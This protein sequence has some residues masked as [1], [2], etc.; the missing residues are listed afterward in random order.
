[1]EKI[2]SK[3]NRILSG[4]TGWLMV[5]MMLLL[6]ADVA[7]RT[8]GKPLQGVAEIS[9]FVMMIVIYLGF[10]RC[11]EHSE[12]VRLEFLLD[13][14]PTSARRWTNA[15]AQL[16]AVLAVGLLLYSVTLDAWSSFE[17]GDAIEGTVEMQIW[18]TKFVMVLGLLFFFLQAIIN[19]FDPKHRA[20][21][22]TDD[23]IDFE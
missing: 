8:V 11:E 18:P 16:L 4:F 6:V 3:I 22:K 15:L 7:W 17:F 20:E 14:L 2:V 9:V 13:M 1:M 12:H 21:E 19:L 23:P 5:A 10:A